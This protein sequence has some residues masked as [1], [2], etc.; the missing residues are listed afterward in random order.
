MLIVLSKSCKSELQV[1]RAPSTG[2]ILLGTCRDV[3]GRKGKFPP[4]F[5]MPAEVESVAALRTDGCPLSMG[6]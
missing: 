1:A 5:F 4:L 3:V 6:D 2:I